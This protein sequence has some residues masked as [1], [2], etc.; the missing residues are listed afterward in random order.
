MLYQIPKNPGILFSKIPGSGFESNPGI[1]GFPGSR[2]GL[3]LT[4]LVPIEKLGTV[5]DDDTFSPVWWV[6]PKSQLG[7]NCICCWKTDLEYTT[8]KDE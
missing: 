4:W 7:K 3:D 6:G 8:I 5:G 1:P 2:R